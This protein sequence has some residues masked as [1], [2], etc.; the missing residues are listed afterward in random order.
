MRSL[1]NNDRF[2]PNRS[3]QFSYVRDGKDDAQEN[4]FSATIRARLA[5][6]VHVK[7]HD[8]TST[9]SRRTQ[10]CAAALRESTTGPVDVAE[11]LHRAA[12]Y[13]QTV[14]YSAVVVDQ[15]LVDA[16]PVEAEMLAQHMEMA[17]PLYVNFAV[18]GVERV[19]RE[20]RLALPRRKK[21][22]SNARLSAQQNLRNEWTKSC[23]W[24]M[25]PATE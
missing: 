9:S 25:N 23:W 8:F 7:R 20:L 5:A 1:R 4:F 17:T 19:V 13:L 2:S 11:S 10:E 12:K 21:E 22:E 3:L 24:P 18:S 6:E 14:N 15:L 16:E